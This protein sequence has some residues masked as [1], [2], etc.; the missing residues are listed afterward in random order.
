MKCTLPMY[1]CSSAGPRICYAVLSPTPRASISRFAEQDNCRP[2]LC[3]SSVVS[4]RPSRIGTEG[5]KIMTEPVAPASR[6]KWATRSHIAIFIRALHLLDLDLLPDWPKISESSFQTTTSNNSSSSSSIKASSSSTQPQTQTQN[7]HHRIKAVEWTLYRLF[8]LYDPDEARAKLA[9]HFPPMTPVQSLS[10]R[11]ALYRALTELKR[12]GALPREIVLRKTM[13]DECRGDKFEELIA[14]FAMVVL[15]RRCLLLDGRGGGGGVSESGRAGQTRKEN[16]ADHVAAPASST[17]GGGGGGPTSTVQGPRPENPGHLVP[18][19]IAHRVL[20]QRS[21]E[22]RRDVRGRAAAYSEALAQLQNDIS[23]RLQ[24]ASLS[25]SAEDVEAVSEE[26]LESLR[27]RVTR[28]FGLVPDARWTTYVF[29]GNPSPV[30]RLTSESLRWPFDDGGYGPPQ[31]EQEDDEGEGQANAPM[32]ELQ[33]TILRHEERIRRL[34]GMRESL[35]PS[36]TGG[37]PSASASASASLSSALTA[38]KTAQTS[39]R[40]NKNEFDSSSSSVLSSKTPPRFNR[41]QSLTLRSVGVS[42]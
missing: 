36:E 23:A 25:E 17:K 32:E 31:F 9:A 1:V 19:I 26:E 34:V 13:L 18:L 37:E 6:P 42:I 11:A 3:Y 24:T 14:G 20:L 5:Q 38:F 27:H 21:L 35:I 2:R 15:R 41:H 4:A 12:T 29:E 30:P 40:R 7:L 8:E 33:A 10:L 28:G 39:S 22:R 16:L